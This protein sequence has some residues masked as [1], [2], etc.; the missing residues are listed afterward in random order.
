MNFE[1]LLKESKECTDEPEP[2]VVFKFSEFKQICRNHFYSRD[3]NAGAG[4]IR[5]CCYR[6]KMALDIVDCKAEN[7]KYINGKTP[8][9]GDENK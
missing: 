3:M 2:Y 1:E 8:H 4:E 6:D 9:A 7:C 5:E